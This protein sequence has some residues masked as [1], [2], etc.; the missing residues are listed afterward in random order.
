MVATHGRQTAH[1]VFDDL[2]G[3]PERKAGARDAEY[4]P[5]GH[6]FD[7]TARHADSS[8]A[9]RLEETELTPAVHPAKNDIPLDLALPSPLTN[10]SCTHMLAPISEALRI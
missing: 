6:R 10:A 5:D 3:R 4:R 1:K 9:A 7:P 2:S 8:V